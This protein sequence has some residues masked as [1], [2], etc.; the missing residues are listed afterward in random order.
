LAKQYGVN[1]AFVHRIYVQSR[2]TDGILLH[3]SSRLRRVLRSAATL[4]NAIT[5][6]LAGNLGSIE[7]DTASVGASHR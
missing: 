1:A 3:V 7:V 6:A 2:R 4:D 5:L